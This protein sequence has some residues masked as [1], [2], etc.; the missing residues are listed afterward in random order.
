[1]SVPDE[2]RALISILLIIY[3]AF[4]GG[5]I[6]GFFL[7]LFFVL[8]VAIGVIFE[9]ISNFTNFLGIGNQMPTMNDIS[10]IVLF[11]VFAA[12][13]GFMVGFVPGA[14]AGIFTAIHIFRKGM[15]DRRIC[16][17]YSIV[18]VFIS[19]LVLLASNFVEPVFSSFVLYVIISCCAVISAYF[20]A[21]WFPGV[22]FE[23]RIIDNLEE[24]SHD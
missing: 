13:A 22:L 19:F 2:K 15:F 10:S 17:F 3:A 6:G 16:C 4:L 21:S 8:L 9:A 11:P 23:L 12:I 7:G 14:I 5:P 20:L 1:M 18:T 24:N